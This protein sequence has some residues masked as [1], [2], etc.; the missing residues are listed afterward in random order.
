MTRGGINLNNGIQNILTRL[1]NVNNSDANDYYDDENFLMCGN[2][3]TRKQTI[4]NIPYMGKGKIKVPVLCKCG[5]KKR[6][7][8]EKQ[9]KEKQR[10]IRIKNIKEQCIAYPQYLNNK[11]SNDDRNNVKIS[12]AVL[13]YIN[14]WDEIYSKNIGILFYGNVG[15]GKT[16]Y[17][18]CIANALIEKEI[19]VIMTNIP[20]LVTSISKDYEINKAYILNR[21]ANIPL[22]ILDDFGEE[23]ITDYEFE[24][25]QEI[26]D[27]RYRSE[28]PLIITTNLSPKT[29]K[30]PQ[31]LRFKRV[32]DRIL[33]MCHPINV[34]GDSHRQAKAKKMREEAKNILNM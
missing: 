6:E 12:E 14:K 31:D 9:E 23:R 21:I 13:R 24:K 34:S 8:K 22:L 17:A 19:P 20:Y 5:S 3:H 11:I 10:L 27:T 4:I 28:K 26:I 18:G 16:F 30:D 1:I 33:A 29:F 2:C 15:I 32:Y 7:E 25:V